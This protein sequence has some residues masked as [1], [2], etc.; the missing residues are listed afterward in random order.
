[1]TM[2]NGE[3]VYIAYVWQVFTTNE[4]FFE[5]VAESRSAAMQRANAWIKANRKAR[6][7]GIQSVTPCN[8]WP[9]CFWAARPK[10]PKIETEILNELQL[11]ENL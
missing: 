9:G 7:S 5:V 4:L 1:M 6:G 3:P 10:Y 8:F 11:P 2:L